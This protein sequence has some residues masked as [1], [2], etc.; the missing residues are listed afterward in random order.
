MQRYS[1][2]RHLGSI[3][4][5]DG[6][7]EPANYSTPA[8]P[9]GAITSIT[10]NYAGKRCIDT[11]SGIRLASCGLSEVPP[12]R[13]APLPIVHVPVRVH[14]QVHNLAGA[15]VSFRAPYP[16]TSARQDYY[17][18]ARACKEIGGSGPNADVAR[19]ETVRIPIGLLLSRRPPTSRSC[20][21]PIR[22]DVEYVRFVN[23]L[24]QPTPI[25]RV[26]LRVPALR[27]GFTGPRSP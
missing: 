13:P 7:D 10:Y 9:N 24:P 1:S 12:P 3:S 20:A 6:R 25:G 5:T 23:G 14:L 18:S 16:V 26:V 2:G 17:V 11:G 19:G 22:I 27:R 15:Y 4:E 21:R 8:A